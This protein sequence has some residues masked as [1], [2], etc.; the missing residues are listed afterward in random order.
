MRRISCS[1]F[2][3]YS[4]SQLR[5]GRF[6]I[7]SGDVLWIQNEEDNEIRQCSSE[8]VLLNNMNAAICSSKRIIW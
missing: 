1:T 3:A 7:N 4:R 6:M 5:G 8:R 2:I